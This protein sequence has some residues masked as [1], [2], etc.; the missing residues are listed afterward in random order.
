MPV[1]IPFG[2]AVFAYEINAA[3]RW[4]KPTPSAGMVARFGRAMKRPSVFAI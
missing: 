1:A 4:W 2:V 3:I